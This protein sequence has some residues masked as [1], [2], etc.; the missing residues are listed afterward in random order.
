MITHV[1]NV[2]FL[3]VSHA[4]RPISNGRAPAFPNLWTFRCLCLHPLTQNDH[5]RQCNVSGGVDCFRSAT[6]PSED[7]V[8]PANPNF[9]GS[10]LLMRTR[11]DVE[12]PNSAHG[13]GRAL[14]EPHHCIMHK[15]VTRFVNDSWVSSVTCF[16]IVVTLQFYDSQFN[17]LLAV[18]P[19]VK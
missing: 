14:G 1:W 16:R 9:G 11:F 19:T 13:E 12:R 2:V 6:P 5:V 18:L 8:I 3:G 10:P 17:G 7:S 15:C 4:S